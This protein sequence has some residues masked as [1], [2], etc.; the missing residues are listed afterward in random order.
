MNPTEYKFIPVDFDPFGA[1]EI[2]KVIP[3]IES[4]KEIWLSCVI[5]GVKA[6][7]A[8]NESISLDFHGNLQTAELKESLETL[9]LRHE[10]LRA[11][12]SADGGK[13]IILTTAPL[14]YAYFDLSVIPK[15]DQSA[16]IEEYHKEDI[17]TAF[18]LSEASL[19]KFTL[20][21]KSAQAYLFT[22]KVHHIICDGWSIEVL[23]K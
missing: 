21:K 4:Q 8:Y 6:N 1:G 7:L 11:S 14:K 15:H 16:R 3:T 23:L 5:G 22:I 9:L 10:S 20:F 12:F 17:A 2:E 13:M 19:I 18:D